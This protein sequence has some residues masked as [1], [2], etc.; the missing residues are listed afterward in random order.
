MKIKFIGHIRAYY[1]HKSVA[2]IELTE[3]VC[4]GNRIYVK[5]ITTDFEQEIESLQI[6]GK[7]VEKSL[8][9]ILVGLKVKSRCRKNDLVYKLLL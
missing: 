7:A 5:G 2:S 8:L 9:G 3:S 6:Q 4:L 1:S